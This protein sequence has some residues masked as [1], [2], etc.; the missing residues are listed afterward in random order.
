MVPGSQPGAS[1]TWPFG[2]QR[3]SS[4]PSSPIYGGRRSTGRGL[5]NFDLRVEQ[6]VVRCGVLC[7]RSLGYGDDLH[8]RIGIWVTSRPARPATD[9]QVS[10]DHAGWGS[11]RH[12]A[13][14]ESCMCAARNGACRGVG[15]PPRRDGRMGIMQASAL[16]ATC[17]CILLG[18][19][20]LEVGEKYQFHR[21]WSWLGWLAAH[22]GWIGSALFI[23]GFGAWGVSAAFWG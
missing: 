20:R 12:R 9:R 18:A 13:Y 10:Q 19:A 7:V 17:S 15:V 3:S 5:A 22:A 8:G 2:D 11:G 21:R 14:M 1:Q 16:A 23:V 4:R 6:L